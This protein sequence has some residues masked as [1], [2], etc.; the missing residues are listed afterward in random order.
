MTALPT[1]L[2]TTL[3]MIVC[4][5]ETFHNQYKIYYIEPNNLLAGGKYRV[6]LSISLSVHTSHKLNSSQTDKQILMKFY[7]AVV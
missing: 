4:M 5:T 1:S 3:Y 7:T 2:W 6:S